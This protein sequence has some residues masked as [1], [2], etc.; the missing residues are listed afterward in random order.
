MDA[1][2]F[3]DI[4]VGLFAILMALMG[5]GIGR[6][7]SRTHDEIRSIKASNESILQSLKEHRRTPLSHI[8]RLWGKPQHRSPEEWFSEVASGQMNPLDC[9]RAAQQAAKF[10]A[11]HEAMSRGELDG[12]PLDT[13]A[14]IY[15]KYRPGNQNSIYPP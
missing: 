12:V 6:L 9:I 8:E 15:A 3:S 1:S 4:A 13:L 2:F 10:E 11:I 5:G 14:S 7:I